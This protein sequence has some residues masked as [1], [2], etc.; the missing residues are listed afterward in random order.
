MVV[1]GR[2]NGVLNT[3][4]SLREMNDF[5]KGNET[6]YLEREMKTKEENSMRN[7]KVL[8]VYNLVDS[9]GNKLQLR[10]GALQSRYDDVCI[11]S[12]DK[13]Y[14]WSFIGENIP[15]PVRS[16]YWFN[17]FQE[18]TMMNWLM[19]NGW[20]PH[21]CVDMHSGK[22]RVYELPK[23]NEDPTPAYELS[24]AAISGGKR[25]M[26]DAIKM[27]CNNGYVLKAVAL[28][29]Y[30]NHSSLVDAKNAVDAIRFDGQ[31]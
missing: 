10:L 25:A 20:H 22:T 18:A 2:L 23:G 5:Y 17:G 14:R 11:S 19:D 31:A 26:E 15:M 1:R 7:V 3:L 30:V 21:T 13:G 24:K 12:A 8:R 29:R 4:Y 16:G 27:L 28:Y 9:K 6:F